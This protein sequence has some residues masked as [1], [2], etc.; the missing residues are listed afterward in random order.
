M[1]KTIFFIL[2]MFS[3]GSFAQRTME[4][5]DVSPENGVYSGDNNEAG[6]MIT[7]PSTMAPLIFDSSMDQHVNVVKTDE[8]NGK[9]IYT[10]SFPCGNRYRGRVLTIGAGGFNSGMVTLELTPKQ[11]RSFKLSDPDATVGVGC[12]RE[13]RNKANNAFNAGKYTEAIDLY[14]IS[15]ECSDAD[16]AEAIRNIV[17][18]D[19]IIKLRKKADMAF[20][21]LKYYDAQLLYASCLSLNPFDEFANKRQSECVENQTT[22]CN[23]NFQNAET[24]YNNHDYD[25]AKI[26]YQRVVDD[27]CMNTTV[28]I[29]RL[30]EIEAMQSSKRDHA[31]VLTYES[32]EDQSIG[33]STG[34]YRLKRVGGYFTLR[35]NS[36]VFDAGRNS[37]K[38]YFPSNMSKLTANSKEKDIEANPDFIPEANLS[39]GWT[40][41]VYHMNIIKQAFAVHAFFGPGVTAKMQYKWSTDAVK[42]YKN[43]NV[44]AKTEEDLLNIDE[45]TY[46][47]KEYDK[48][49]KFS[50]SPEIGFCIRWSY[51]AFRYTFQYRFAVNKDDQDFL[52]KTRS[53][54]GVGLAF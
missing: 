20:M 49:F 35:F 15:S 8:V 44:T 29:S 41:P 47:T 10:L 24:Y 11:L 14:K 42:E 13:N 40:I 16:S 39:F 23:T 32:S 52:G 17:I 9:T 36:E 2:V 34:S 6:V 26:L 46:A 51:I 31:H 37:P 38:F 53:V 1:K 45:D 19:S 12:Y 50:I 54:I 48:T 22:M 27:K 30:T 7:C 18:T 3:V 4:I 5:K 28:A 33:I 25:K 43:N 21:A